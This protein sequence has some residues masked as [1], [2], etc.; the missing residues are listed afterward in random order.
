[1]TPDPFWQICSAQVRCAGQSAFTSTPSCLTLRWG[2]RIIQP[3][4]P[5]SRASYCA[6]LFA[7]TQHDF[8]SAHDCPCD[9]D[10]NCQPDDHSRGGLQRGRTPDAPVVRILEA[11]NLQDARKEYYQTKTYKP[12][13]K[14]GLR[15]VH[16]IGWT[17]G[18]TMTKRTRNYPRNQQWG[19]DKA[20]LECAEVERVLSRENNASCI[21]LH[22]SPENR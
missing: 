22:E 19:T 3:R 2:V 9:D 6:L 11:E 15:V 16:E 1:M 14:W 20:L 4:A 18:I 5:F 12:T 13:D 7:V 21:D 8:A 17:L 10:Q